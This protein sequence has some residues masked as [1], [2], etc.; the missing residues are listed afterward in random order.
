MKKDNDKTIPFHK[1]NFCGGKGMFP[2]LRRLGEALTKD[3][4]NNDCAVYLSIYEAYNRI[5]T[6]YDR[7]LECVPDLSESTMIALNSRMCEYHHE[8]YEMYKN[9]YAIKKYREEHNL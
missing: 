6:D 2:Q 9:N 3:Y 7:I 8:L 4:P 1:G 5:A